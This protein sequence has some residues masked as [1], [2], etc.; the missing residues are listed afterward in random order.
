MV[1]AIWDT[2][3]A[4]IVDSYP[5]E[6]KALADV[7]DAVN[8]FGRDYA[9]TWALARHDDDQVEAIAEGSDLIDRAMRD[10]P[11]MPIHKQTSS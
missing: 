2:A 11:S 9:L 4:N 5:S 7:R 10:R 1:Y 3:S 6:S 8:Q